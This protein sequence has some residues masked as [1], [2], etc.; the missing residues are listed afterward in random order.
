MGASLMPQRVTDDTS[1]YEIL[2][3]VDHSGN[4]SMTIDIVAVDYELH[5]KYDIGI[6]SRIS[7]TPHGDENAARL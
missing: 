5:E 6:H 3:L 4:T 1:V 2:Q 7:I